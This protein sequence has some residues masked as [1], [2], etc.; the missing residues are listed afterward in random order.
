MR[1]LYVD[2]EPEIREIAEIALSLDPDFEVRTAGSGAAALD[3]MAEWKP[4]VV[5][6][7]VM[8][9]KMDG[10]ELLG[11]IRT[12]DDLSSLPVIFVTARAQRSELQTFHT[13]DSAGVI[14][15]PFDPMTLALE[16]RK[17]IA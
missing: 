8:M 3:I 16:V 14:A 4:D 10:P 13:L 6:L 15:K 2:D 17:I 12:L 1:V 9:P 7:D 5:L 11:K